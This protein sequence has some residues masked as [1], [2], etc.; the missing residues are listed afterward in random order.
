MESIR[1]FLRTANPEYVKL[2]FVERDKNE[3]TREI[4]YNCL[5]TI[6]SSEIA[7]EV[8]DSVLKHVSATINHDPEYFEYGVIPY[9]DRGHIETI[10]PKEIPHFDNLVKQISDPNIPLFC[11]IGS[12][13]IGY[14]IKVQNGDNNLLLFKRY[15]PK[16]ILEKGKLFFILD[17]GGFEKLNQDIASLDEKIDALTL[18]RNGKDY[19]NSTVFILNRSKFESF[20]GFVDFYIEEINNKKIEFA[21]Q[22]LVDN[23]DQLFEICKKNNIMVKK[24]ARILKNGTFNGMSAEKAKCIKNDFDLNVEFDENGKIMV[25]DE[26]IWTI[27]RILDDDHL[28]SQATDGKYEARS[29][30]KK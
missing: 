13:T 2:F 25:C 14:I 1:E 10:A 22:K 23:E 18:I 4:K 17:T 11:K 5:K 24:F 28:H 9:S 16:K 20:F 26:K 12:K 8:L 7:R 21:S 30:V 29:K 19:L 27:L 3:E 6:I 15:S